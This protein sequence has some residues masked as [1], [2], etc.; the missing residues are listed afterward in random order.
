[1]ILKL[2]IKNINKKSEIIKYNEK[3]KNVRKNEIMY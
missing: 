1:M 3:L 2:K